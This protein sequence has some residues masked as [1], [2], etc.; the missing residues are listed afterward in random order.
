[1]I[2]SKT[3][4]FRSRKPAKAVKGKPRAAIAEARRLL[5]E[6]IRQKLVSYQAIRHLDLEWSSAV[7][8]GTAE[9]DLQKAKRFQSHYEEWMVGTDEI[10]RDIRKMQAKGLTIAGSL[11]FRHTVGYCP[12]GIDIEQTLATF[13]RLER[14]EGVVINEANFDQIFPPRSS[15]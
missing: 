6:R 9:F 8:A 11:D 1:M 12:A 13:E 14:G 2:R 3:E 5:E 10:L 7:E 4:R 15:E